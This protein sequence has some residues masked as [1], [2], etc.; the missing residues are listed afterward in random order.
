MRAVWLAASAALLAFL[1]V[2]SLGQD[3]PAASSAQASPR[4][5]VEQ[6]IVEPIHATPAAADDRREPLAESRAPAADPDRPMERRAVPLRG[7]LVSIDARGR[8]LPPADGELEVHVWMPSAQEV[9]PSADGKDPE[10][11]QSL[12]DRQVLTLQVRQGRW[13]TSLPAG[14]SKRFARGRLGDR[15]LFDL[16]TVDDAASGGAV[17]V[18]GRVLGP[19]RLRVVDRSSQRDLDAVQVVRLEPGDSRAH[20]GR[21]APSFAA[22]RSPLEIALSG[23]Q[24]ETWLIGAEGHAWQRVEWDA[25]AEEER[26]VELEPGGS[27]A[28]DVLTQ[29]EREERV[30]AL[31]LPGE[32]RS[33][34]E[35]PAAGELPI[36]LDGVAPGEYVI[37]L[38][39]APRAVRSEWP[40]L[41]RSTALV[42]AGQTDTVVLS[43]PTTERPPTVELSGTLRMS[44]DWSPGGPHL[45]V[46][47]LGPT[48]FW[49]MATD[50][51]LPGVELERRGA[52]AWGFR[53]DSAL[54]GGR[55]VILE[56]LSGFRREF[57]VGAAGATAGEIAIPAPLALEVEV[58]D[59]A[60]GAPIAGCALTW[61]AA[62]APDAAS[63][64]TSAL[65]VDTSSEAGLFHLRVPQDE[66]VELEARAEGYVSART[67]L[68]ASAQLSGKVRIA[69]ERR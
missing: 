36:T 2:W 42:I 41:A 18:T 44:P 15:P 22:Q 38:V 59:D 30:V 67:D 33:Y 60:S 51:L 50:G 27:L 32:S 47:A 1:A 24:R 21:L 34:V 55:Y 4:A 62:G 66:R 69:L 63:P 8:E 12:R 58:V 53:S 20:P 65:R 26:T 48:A 3:R 49:H 46:R 14:A 57:E 17:R 61:S 31:S 16:Q 29:G 56:C 7:E 35:L 5:E 43:E 11:R 39:P 19:A 54:A 25:L 6:Q 64:S 40:V 52:D 23:V 68:L 9:G 37:A 45:L 10:R 13:E 28:I